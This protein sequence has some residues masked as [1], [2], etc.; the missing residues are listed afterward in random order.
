MDINSRLDERFFSVRQYKMAC[1][2]RS[3]VYLFIQSH[4]QVSVLYMLGMG[5]GMRLYLSLIKFYA[6]VVNFL[7]TNNDHYIITPV[8][9]VSIVDGDFIQSNDDSSHRR[10]DVRIITTLCNVKT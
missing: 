7:Q 1:K 8:A 2:L 10:A 6:M 3:Q 9:S 4:S 5:L